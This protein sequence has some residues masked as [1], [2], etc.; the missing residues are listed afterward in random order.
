MDPE[1]PSETSPKS[2]VL[3]KADLSME[4]QD[5]ASNVVSSQNKLKH[6]HTEGQF[7]KMSARHVSGCL[8]VKEDLPRMTDKNWM[9]QGALIAITCSDP[10]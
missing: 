6:A 8:R 5:G 3:T 2:F 4:L 10:M 1:F 9:E 7:N